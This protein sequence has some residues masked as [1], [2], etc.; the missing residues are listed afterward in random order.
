[1][2]YSILG[3]PLFN[4][5]FPYITHNSNVLAFK[6]IKIWVPISTVSNTPKIYS[7]LSQTNS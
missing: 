3:S 4:T 5:Q 1:M 7:C 2:Y 6:K